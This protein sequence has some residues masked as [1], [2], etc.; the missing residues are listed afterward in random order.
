MA[1]PCKRFL[2]EEC[3]ACGWCMGTLEDD[4]EDDNPFEDFDIDYDERI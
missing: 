1:Y 3:D 4:D 2:K